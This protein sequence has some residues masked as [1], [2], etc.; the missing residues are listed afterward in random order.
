MG[1]KHIL[2]GGLVLWGSRFAPR[3]VLH[4]IV[5]VFLATTSMG[6][7]VLGLAVTVSVDG[8]E[9]G[10]TPRTNDVALALAPGTPVVAVLVAIGGDGSTTCHPED[11]A[12]RDAN[13]LN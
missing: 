9:P 7:S 12:E 2:G 10:P 6:C 11:P 3:G 8:Q 1:W 13:S 4:G 5:V